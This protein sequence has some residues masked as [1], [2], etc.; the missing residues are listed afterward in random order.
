VAVPAT[1]HPQSAG[2][3][4]AAGDELGYPV[5]VK[6]SEPVGF[7]QRFR[8]QAF[9][10]E[11][12]AALR[13]AYVRAEAYEPMVQELVPGGDSELYTL[14]SHLRAD[15]EPLALFCGRKLRQ[16]PPIVGTCRV[17]E[18]LWV[19]EVVE[20]GLRLL[21]A[22]AYT[23][24]SQVEFKRDPRDGRFKLMEINP[25]LWLWHGLATA[26]GVDVPVLAYRDLTGERVLPLT[27]DGARRRWAI[28]LVPHEKPML[29]RPPDVEAIWARDDLRPVAIHVARYVRNTLR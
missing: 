7:K 26:C 3:A 28:A 12:P 21:R 11:S 16:T 20:S 1:A 17:G 9:R 24:V 6:P 27:S 25:R 8:R 10:C 13:D 15:G 23:G 5:L 19:D 14:G 4:Q 22:F 29:V 18:A 2:E